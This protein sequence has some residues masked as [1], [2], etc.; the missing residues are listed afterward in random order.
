MTRYEGADGPGRIKGLAFR[1]FAIWYAEH[2]DADHTSSVVRELEPVYPNVFDVGRRGYGILPTRWYEARLVHR[3]LD[4]L[5]GPQLDSEIDRLTQAAAN[6]IMGRTLSGVYAFLFSA[7]ASPELYARHANKLWGLHYDSG[8]SAIV[9]QSATEAT[10]RYAGWRG[11]HPLIC[12]LNMAA[13]VPIYQAVGCTNVR[14][15]RLACVDH[16]KPMCEMLVR[17]D[18]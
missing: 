8:T 6:D 16:G 12:R 11:H 4:Q 10:L 3:F 13:A 14:W 5:V 17:W 2:V 18:P 1:E 9:Q 7:L 15:T